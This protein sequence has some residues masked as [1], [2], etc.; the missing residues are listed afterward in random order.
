M[1]TTLPS[2]LVWV[3]KKF[4]LIVFLMA[5]VQLL[6]ISVWGQ[7]VTTGKSYINISRPTGGTFLPGDI[8]EVRA[9][10]AV[11]G[12]SN[13]S[14][15]RLNFVRYNDTINLTQFSY[16]A[17]SLV[18]QTNDGRPQVPG[19]GIPAYTDAADT[20][21]AHIN[22]VTGQIRFNIGRGSGACD[23]TTQTNTITNAGN[24]WGGNFMRPS[25]F[26]G[27]CIR[28][29]A[30]RLRILNTPTVNIDDLVR[31]NAGNFRY[32]VGSSSTDVLSNFSPYF[33]RIAPDYGL[34][35]NSIGANAIV[36][37]S[38]GTFGS[39]MAQNRAGGTPFVPPPY[40]FVNFGPGSPNDNF[41]GLANRTS[42]D[43]TT[44]PNVNYSSGAGSSSR[45]HNVWD[46][47]GDHT[48]AVDPF[49]GNPPTN[50]G[51]AVIINAS[52]ETN[53]AFTQTITGLCENTYYEF[54][55]WFRNICRR[56][57]SDSSG[58]GATDVGFK[59]G[60]DTV[61]LWRDSSGVRPNLSFQI[62][63]EEFYTSGNIPYTNSWIKKGFVYR[64]RPGQ[65]SMVVT[66]RNNAPGGGGNDWAIDDIGVSTCLPNMK[67]SPSLTP[68]ICNNGA[69][70][71]NDT[72][73]SFFDNYVYYKWQRSADNGI[74]WADVSPPTG[75]VLP[76][77]NPNLHAI[78]GGWEYVASYTIPPTMT[79]PWN[80]G[81]KYRVV[82]ATS[83]TNLSNGNC[84]S[85]DAT[86]TITLSVTTCG[87]V[88]NVNLVTFNGKLADKKSQ[89]K[90][91]T[92]S[93]QEELFYDVEKSFDGSNFSA[94]A[95]IHGNSASGEANEY[96]YTD[97]IEV[98]GK[99][100]YRLKMRSIDNRSLY[101]RIVQV[102]AVPEKFGFGAVVNPF[103]STL[104]FDITVSKQ[105]MVNAELVNQFG[106]TIRTKSLDAKEGNNQFF[107]ENT[108]G[109]VPGIYVLKA[110]I[111]G[112]IIYRK[113]IKTN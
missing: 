68:N 11:T 107:F 78:P 16:V 6:P 32:R 10:I 36:G 105:G 28:V 34:C 92:A 23:V 14:T 77:P 103:T 13:T 59:P 48:G 8:I 104:Y 60:P 93:E 44:N 41:Y 50:Q 20:D 71:I 95:T 74:T 84:R 76:G 111:D 61:G 67:Y 51:Y 40:S 9:T 35:S 73:R 31:L 24:L 109:L 89:L 49:A 56:C 37:E 100:Y 18:M 46:I 97:P 63:G 75:P 26:G 83:L 81:D 43:G 27:T 96:N 113:V 88:L 22:T 12:G 57:S 85:T 106:K 38:G 19:L 3:A 42:T 30:Y 39:G 70:T 62:N 45:V 101:S 1:K 4:T 66:I 5:L 86:N 98:T 87:P 72:V 55:A 52:Y 58:K 65:T 2:L 69:L 90:W 29:Y 102:S 21:S 110:E 108:S 91:T 79:Y 99:V 112:A 82:V 7:T 17:N 53:R 33:I 80:S 15:A 54:S 25:F 64:T 47:I 94:I